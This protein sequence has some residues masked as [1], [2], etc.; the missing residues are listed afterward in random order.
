MRYL[1]GKTRLAKDIMGAITANVD[2]N[3]RYIEPFVGG[4]SVLAEAAKYFTDVHAGDLSEDLILLW[5]ALQ[6]GWEPPADMTQVE[7][8]SLRHAEPSA[9]RG[10]AGFPCSFSGKWFGGMGQGG[11][12]SNGLPRNHI[13]EGRRS[14][15]KKAKHIKNVDFQRIGY[16]EWALDSNTI[17]YCDPPYEAT[18]G[19]DSVKGGWDAKAFWDWATQ[20]YTKYGALIFVSELTAP[21]GWLPYWKKERKVGSTVAV[22]GNGNN[23]SLQF[24]YLFAPADFIHQM[25]FLPGSSQE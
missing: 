18:T 25:V 8:E 17:V 19:Y 7:Y 1:G 2:K 22:H 20:A 21:D 5:K 24:D 11:L 23:K 6:T 9:L 10:F 15:L 4:G 14:C 3:K 12:R 13:D 16:S